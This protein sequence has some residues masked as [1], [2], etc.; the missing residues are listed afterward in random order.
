MLAVTLYIDADGN[1][2]AAGASVGDAAGLS[3]I[4]WAVKAAE[5]LS[6]PSPGSYPAKVM[7]EG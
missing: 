1:V 2:M 7:I 4:D 6:F 5:G 3:A